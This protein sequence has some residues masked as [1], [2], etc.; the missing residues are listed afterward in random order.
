MN[1]VV[2]SYIFGVGIRVEPETPTELCRAVCGDIAS[3]L[4]RIERGATR[5]EVVEALKTTLADAE[6]RLTIVLCMK[7]RPNV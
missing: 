3:V 6:D 7:D 1:G 4:E 5:R 2:G